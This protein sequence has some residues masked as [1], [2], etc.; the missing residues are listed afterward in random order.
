MN[1]YEVMNARKALSMTQ[2]TLAEILGTTVASISRWENG[3]AAP[4]RTYILQ[5]K[6]LLEEYAN[7]TS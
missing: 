4:N 6:K 1:Q 7:K 3:K 5:I 2:E